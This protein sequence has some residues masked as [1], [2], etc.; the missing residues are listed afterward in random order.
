MKRFV[1]HR[2]ASDEA[3]IFTV[4]NQDE[5]DYSDY[6]ED[7]GSIERVLKHAAVG[8][9][10][11]LAKSRYRTTANV[12]PTSNIVERLFILSKDIMRPTCDEWIH[13]RWIQG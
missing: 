2:D 7:L 4:G 9:H 3:K 5:N 6:S 11:N 13:R 12:S 1:S 8:K 10:L